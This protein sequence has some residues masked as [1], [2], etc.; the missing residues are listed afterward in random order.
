MGKQWKQ[1]DFIFLGSKITADGD[2]RHEIKRRLVLGRKG[3]TNLDS[4]FKR[5]NITDKGPSSQ[6][7]GFSSR[8]VW[9]WELDHKAEHQR[10]DAFCFF[11][12]SC[13]SFISFFFLICSEFCH[14]L[15]WNGLEFTCLPHPDPPSHLPLH[16]LPPGLPRAPVPS[17]CLM[18]PTWAG[19]L[20]HPW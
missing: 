17:A 7:Y 12:L 15:K 10:I 18:H 20:F 5:R 16:P 11:I 1:R 4:I 9:M 14:T 2:C 13:Y 3:M 19:D 6:S 8:H